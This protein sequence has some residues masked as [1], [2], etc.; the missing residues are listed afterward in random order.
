MFELDFEILGKIMSSLCSWAVFVY[1]DQWFFCLLQIRVF[2][3]HLLC[4]KTPL[5][6]FIVK[7]PVLI[8]H[9]INLS[10]CIVLVICLTNVLVF[11]LYE[12]CLLGSFAW[13]HECQAWVLRHILGRP[14]ECRSIINHGR[15]DAPPKEQALALFVMILQKLRW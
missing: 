4:K 1:S 15:C 10:V 11:Y 6:R 7:S 3:Y 2:C 5:S 8:Q 13:W 9:S 14:E 12:R